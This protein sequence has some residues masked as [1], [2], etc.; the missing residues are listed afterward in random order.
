MVRVLYCMKIASPRWAK[1]LSDGTAWFG[2]VESYIQ[3]AQKDHN[4]EQGD[5]FEGIFARVWRLS[6][7]LIG[8][9]K[10]FG[11]ELEIIPDGEYCLLRRK[12]VRKACIFCMYGLTSNDF[13]PVS[14]PYY[15]D[16]VEVCDFEH[17]VNQKMFDGFLGSNEKAASV[18][19]S[20]GHLRDAI[21]KGAT[22][23]GYSIKRQELKYDLDFTQVFEIKEIEP[24]SPY[25]E[26]FHKRKRFSYQ[27][28]IRSLI[29][30]G[31]CPPKED[32][33][34]IQYEKLG[35]DSL[36]YDESNDNGM[37]IRMTASFKMSNNDSS[38]K[39]V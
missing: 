7:A 36:F 12:S 30:N 32:G 33:I 13:K 27:H 8:Y 24:G 16:G 5:E 4:D 35:K 21:S 19:A 3:K 23:T 15:K 22:I 25:E 31:S 14:K 34:P 10:K 28:E 29:S 39:Q 20:A 2:S 26:L 38:E 9:M 11:D 17:S 1:S 18:C 6:D 37:I